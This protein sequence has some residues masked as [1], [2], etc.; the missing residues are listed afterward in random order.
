MQGDGAVRVLLERIAEPAALPEPDL[1]AIGDALLALARDTDTV[2]PWIRQLGDTSGVIPI[3]APDRGPRLMLVHRLEGQMGA[4]HD[5]RTWVAIAPVTGLETHRRYRVHGTG[6][7]AR[8]VLEDAVALAPQDVVTLLP[9]DDLHDHG[10]LPG[11]GTPAYILILTGDDQRRFERNEWDLATGRHRLLRP[12]D[13]GRW[14][15]S[16]PVP[17]AP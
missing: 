3:H 13:P 14:L 16:D 8:P 12:G 15:A 9:P 4:V 17:P 11:F 10:H 1:L 5:H 2:G 6:T 7:D